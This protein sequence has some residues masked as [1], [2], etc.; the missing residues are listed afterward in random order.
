MSAEKKAKMAKK[1]DTSGDK[2][3]LT[4]SNEKITPDLDS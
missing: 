4:C 2:C 1:R 3:I